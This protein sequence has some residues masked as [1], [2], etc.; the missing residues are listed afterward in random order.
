[1]ACVWDAQCLFS[2]TESA[3]PTAS[4]CVQCQLR[5][6]TDGYK[7]RTDRHLILLTVGTEKGSVLTRELQ[8]ETLINMAKQQCGGRDKATPTADR[9]SL[10]QQQ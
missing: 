2:V 8:T 6:E 4:V 1:M 5:G 9:M 10:V 7:S 3:T